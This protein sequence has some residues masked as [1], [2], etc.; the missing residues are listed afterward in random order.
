MIQIKSLAEMFTDPTGGMASKDT[1]AA[2]NVY[3]PLVMVSI[4]A[5]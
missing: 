1:K 4:G 3:V 2:E 5:W